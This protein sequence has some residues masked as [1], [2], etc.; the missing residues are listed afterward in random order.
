M[1][2]A[3]VRNPTPGLA[4]LSETIE[5]M[6]GHLEVHRSVIAPATPLFAPDA[7]R[8]DARMRRL[9]LRLVALSRLGSSRVAE[10]IAELREVFCEHVTLEEQLVFPELAATLDPTASEKLNRSVERAHAE[11]RA[12]AAALPGVDRVNTTSRQVTEAV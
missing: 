1:L 10:V 2:T 7:A 11:S 12:R 4:D 5:E 9:L 3:L 8:L 6:V